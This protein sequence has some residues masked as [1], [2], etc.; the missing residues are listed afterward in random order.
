MKNQSVACCLST[1]S[2][3]F[4]DCAIITTPST[5][6]ASATSYETS[7]A[8]VR[9]DPRIEYFDSLAQPPTMKP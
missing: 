5:L 1:I 2:T 6:N 9:I 7:W 3:R 4:S 8:H